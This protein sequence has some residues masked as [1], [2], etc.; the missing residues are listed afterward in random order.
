MK[1]INLIYKLN[2]NWRPGTIK[3]KKA[4]GQT[5]R[6][7]II[8]Y[9]KKRY[10]VRL[11]WERTDIVDR[12]VE[13][14]NVLALVKCKK[15]SR[16]LP[17]YYLYI[18]GGKNILSLTREK[19]NLPDGTMMMEYVSG[20]I[21]TINLFRRKKYQEKLA[22]MFHIFHTSGV[23]FTN[24]YNVFR[25]EIGKYRLIA[26]KYPIQK[27]VTPK[28]IAKFES[29]EKEAKSIIPLL[30]RRVPAHN[31]F[32]FQNFIVGKN[33]KI[34]LLDFEYAGSSEKG[35]IL[36]DFGFLFADN[37][38][39]RPPI[40]Q[41]LFEKFLKLSDKVYKKTLDRKQIYW[42]AVAVTTMQFWW[43][44]LRYFSVKK[45]KEKKYFKDY[46]LKRARGIGFLYQI[47][48]RN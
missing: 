29:V 39:R 18:F 38:F 13:A 23:R 34:Y 41:A 35:G 27:I 15:L 16:I 11:P 47:I 20:K 24:K 1:D 42:L 10:F 36:Y 26:K 45:Q 12:G 40:K 48:S 44:L 46:I 21:F 7:W 3:V 31:D 28:I 25:D 32:I 4:G 8:E 6:N 5:N 14:K 30:K 37:F 33:N 19:F 17:K 43:G 9:K 2:K 22:R